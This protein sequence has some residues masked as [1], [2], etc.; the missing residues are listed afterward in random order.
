MPTNKYQRDMH[1]NIIALKI[2]VLPVALKTSPP[3]FLM[4]RK[5]DKGEKREGKKQV[6]STHRSRA[7]DEGREKTNQ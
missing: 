6:H 5:E 2:N 1:G 3:F 7:T 4:L